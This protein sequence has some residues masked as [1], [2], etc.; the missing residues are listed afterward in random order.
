MMSDGLIVSGLTFSVIFYDFAGQFRA[1]LAAA[2]VRM[3]ADRGTSALSGVFRRNACK[4]N[5]IWMVQLPQ[6]SREMPLLPCNRVLSAREP[7]MKLLTYLV[8]VAAMAG[9]TACDKDK[10]PSS[11]KMDRPSSSGGVNIPPPQSP[12]EPPPPESMPKPQG[13][14][15]PGTPQ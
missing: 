14:R 3:D 11:P 2:A 4:C 13:G 9:L 7:D 10:M 1:I 15:G 6:F 8:L 12:G 5:R